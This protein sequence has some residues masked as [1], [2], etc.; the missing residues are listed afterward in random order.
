M[1]NLLDTIVSGIR[2]GVQNI[3]QNPSTLLDGLI[4]AAAVANPRAAVAA[5]P[6]FNQ[7]YG[8]PDPLK[9]LQQQKLQLEIAQQAQQLQRSQAVQEALTKAFSPDGNIDANMLAGLAKA[10]AM[11][12]DM[13][14]ASKLF[15]MLYVMQKNGGALKPQLVLQSN[16]YNVYAVPDPVDPTQSHLLT[17]QNHYATKAA[18]TQA[19][20][21][22]RLAAFQDQ[23]LG[24]A[25]SGAA[26]GMPP[27]APIVAPEAA[28]QA[29]SPAAGTEAATPPVSAPQA[30]APDVASASQ[31]E[32][33]AAAAVGLTQLANA[34]SGRPELVKAQE[35][36]KK[37]ATRLEK[38][39]EDAQNTLLEWGPKL[40]PV[41]ENT[42]DVLQNF[43]TIY[44]QFTGSPVNKL[45]AQFM[46]DVLGDKAAGRFQATV[47]SLD[48]YLKLTNRMLMKGQGQITD[49]EME[50]AADLQ[51][52]LNQARNP[53][54]VK[55][56]IKTA[57]RIAVADMVARHYVAGIEPPE[58]IKKL[59]Q[60][61]FKEPPE[62]YAQR[63]TELT[64]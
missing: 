41:I 39:K 23:L 58:H 17:I 64:Q 35:R 43:D 57:V 51:G 29:V 46:A 34:I 3:A 6:L 61:I 36:A 63:L 28:A 19:E 50:V 33:E 20:I 21:N 16:G 52:R 60:A 37:S 15:Q 2:T 1:A 48:S 32:R 27:A 9:R 4:M 5:M 22:A 14:T 47:E 10:S 53:D 7:I 25:G 44:R 45:R 26:A 12:G 42:I 38:L 31:M 11:K 55:R 8:S 49:K 24:Q 40:T 13:A 56:I 18:E 62:K 30:A 54:E 59:Y